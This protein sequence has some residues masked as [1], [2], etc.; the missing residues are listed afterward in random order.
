MDKTAAAPPR[1]ATRV[2]LA[3]EFLAL[4]FGVVGAYA[5]AGSPGSPIPFLLVGAVAAYVYLRR[6]PGFERRDLTRAA[7]VPPALPAILA[8]WAV[9]AVVGVVVLAVARPEQLLDLPREEPLLWGLVAVFYP[10]LSVYPQEL[11]YRAFLLHRYAPLLGTG[12]GAATASAAAFGFA[13][14][15]FG[16]V[17]SVLLTLAGGWLFARRYQ[18][19]RSLL[20]ASVEH[21]LYGVLAFTIGFGDLFYHGAR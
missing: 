18:K 17:L 15:I 4:F 20:A 5:L 9:A 2:W 6:Q 21:A 12:A 13:H 3:A 8:G 14:V 1:P 7:A 10:L 11:I 19:S 16:N